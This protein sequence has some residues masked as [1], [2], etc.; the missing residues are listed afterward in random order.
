MG[1]HVL[2]DIGIFL[3]LTFAGI[4]VMLAGVGVMRWGEAKKETR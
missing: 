3:F 4:G 1:H 2:V